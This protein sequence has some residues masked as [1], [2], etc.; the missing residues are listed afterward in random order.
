MQ[1]VELLDGDEDV[2]EQPSPP[3]RDR[4]RLWWVPAGA[5]AVAL[6]LVGTQLVVDAREDAAVARLAAVPGVF[7]PLGDELV[8]LRTISARRRP[9]ASGPA[10]SIGGARTA[11]LVVADGRVA[12]LRR[13]STSAPARRSGPPRCWVRTRSG[14]RR[15]RTATAAGARATPARGE[16]ATVAV[17]LVT[18]GFVRYDD[19]GIEERFPATT[20]QVVVLD[21]GDGHVVTQWDVERDHAA[22]RRRRARRGRDPRR[23]AWRGGRRAR[24]ADR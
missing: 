17:C 21:T 10:S 3:A 5:A 15:W 13:R 23:G 4:R 8:V 6:S 12:V 22:R 16:P 20:S 1:E 19:D 18:D 9:A 24:P 2:A 7:P 11:G 14:P